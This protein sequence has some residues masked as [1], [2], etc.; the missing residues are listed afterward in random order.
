[1]LKLAAELGEGAISSLVGEYSSPAQPR[2]WTV[3]V[4]RR[5]LGVSG[6]TVVPDVRLEPELASYDALLSREVT[7]VG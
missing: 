2:K 4:L 5:V 3:A 6:G 1:L 7:C